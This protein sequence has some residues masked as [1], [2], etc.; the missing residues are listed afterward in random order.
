M[1]YSLI[2]IACALLRNWFKLYSS[3]IAKTYVQDNCS[4][5]IHQA[6]LIQAGIHRYM[7]AYS[8]KSV[9]TQDDVALGLVL[10]LALEMKTRLCHTFD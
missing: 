9:D 3:N 6:Q 2:S 8:V 10:G 7:I 5:G 4:W 1:I